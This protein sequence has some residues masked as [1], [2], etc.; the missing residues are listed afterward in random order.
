[1]E[2]SRRRFVGRAL[3]ALAWLFATLGSLYLVSQSFM[4]GGH[5]EF[6]Q[7]FRVVALLFSVSILLLNAIW[8]ALFARDVVR[9]EGSQYL[10]SRSDEG[11][12]RIS[13]RALQ[14]SL[15]RRVR[16]LD[17]VIGARLSVRR[18]E[19]RRIRVDVSYTTTEDRNAIKVSE[20]LRA[21]VKSRFD[22]L[23]Q[24]EEG[25]TVDFDL[26][27]EGFVPGSGGGEPPAEAVE[28]EPF[29]G[30]RYPID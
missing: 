3:L 19:S 28:D 15:L 16:E 7:P 21:A 6:S 4:S 23:V 29:T 9:G 12:A 20:A 25:F 18:P 26:K 5:W 10:L 30:P 11:S 13:L 2:Q 27:I 24:P 8:F 17:E 22:E 14:A 1:M